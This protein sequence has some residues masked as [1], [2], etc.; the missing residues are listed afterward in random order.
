MPLIVSCILHGTIDQ[1]LSSHKDTVPGET[2]HLNMPNGRGILLPFWPHHCDS[3]KIPLAWYARRSRCWIF[4]PFQIDY[5]HRHHHHLH[6]HHQCWQLNIWNNEHTIWCQWKVLIYIFHN[7]YQ[8]KCPKCNMKEINMSSVEEINMFKLLGT[9]MS[10]DGRCIN[11]VKYRITQA[12][13]AFC[14]I[15]NILCPLRW[16]KKFLIDTLSQSWCKK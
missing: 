3:E 13:A 6:H 1:I 11:T 12:N 4:L 14:K 15:K 7:N 10:V 16:E 5:H 8:K 9:W 2:C